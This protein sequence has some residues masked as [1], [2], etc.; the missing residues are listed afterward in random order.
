MTLTEILMK[1]LRRNEEKLNN[2]YEDKN[3][4]RDEC[5]PDIEQLRTNILNLSL[6]IIKIELGIEDSD[7]AIEWMHTNDIYAL[8]K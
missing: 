2:Y 8:A 7:E 6:M 5:H 1:N 4:T 3:D